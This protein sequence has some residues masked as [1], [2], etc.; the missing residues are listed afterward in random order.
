[1]LRDIPRE[2]RLIL[3]GG[4]YEFSMQLK[5]EH[6]GK[7]T[8]RLAMDGDAVNARFFVDN[9]QARRQIEANLDQLRQSLTEQGLQIDG[10]TV[11]VR[12]D[13]E[14]ALNRWDFWDGPERRWQDGKAAGYDAGM[15]AGSVAK[16][17]AF[18]LKS[19]YGQESSVHYTA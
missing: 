6:L 11:E 9:E 3:D 12:Q 10:C 1:M 19:Y 7:M 13:G 2:A 16:T 5:P 17:R 14:G 15:V 18:M 8:M 4:K